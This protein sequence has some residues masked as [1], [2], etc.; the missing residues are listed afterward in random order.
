MTSKK[1]AVM[2]TSS[3]RP[4]SGDGATE[5]VKKK[6]RKRQGKGCKGERGRQRRSLLSNS[7]HPCLARF[8]PVLLLAFWGS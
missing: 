6:R 7:L 8:G 5:V 2:E 1:T 4:I 3:R